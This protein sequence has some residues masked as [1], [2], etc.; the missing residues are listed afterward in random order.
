MR[1]STVDKTS[2]HV[3]EKET[4]TRDRSVRWELALEQVNSSDQDGC[5]LPPTWHFEPADPIEKELPT[6]F[7]ASLQVDYSWSIVLK[8]IYSNFAI[9]AN[10]ANT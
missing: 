8:N 7:V 3:L 6:P 10:Q 2:F 5:W 9:A 1:H 4:L